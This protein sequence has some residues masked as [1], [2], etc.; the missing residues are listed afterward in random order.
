[1]YCRGTVIHWV[2]EYQYVRVIGEILTVGTVIRIIGSTF[3]SR[4]YVERNWWL[5]GPIE[6]LFG[7]C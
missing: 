2:I 3:A 5:R 7:P 1:M 6:A 4:M